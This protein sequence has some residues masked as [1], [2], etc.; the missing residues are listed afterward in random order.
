MR[1]LLIGPR[2]SIGLE[3]LFL[4]YLSNSSGVEVLTVHMT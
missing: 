3:Y 4:K 1:P 2:E